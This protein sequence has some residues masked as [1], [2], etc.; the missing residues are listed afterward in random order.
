VHGQ[1]IL[2]YHTSVLEDARG[3]EEKG[4]DDQR[5]EIEVLK[6]EASNY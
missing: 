5:S 6:R 4:G 1:D 3:G 2:S